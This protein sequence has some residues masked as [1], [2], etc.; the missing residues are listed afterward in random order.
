MGSCYVKI[1]MNLKDDALCNW[2][3]GVSVQFL[4]QKVQEMSAIAD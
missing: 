1:M 2:K 4:Q 3:T